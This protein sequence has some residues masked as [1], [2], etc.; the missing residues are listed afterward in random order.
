MP[1][2]SSPWI[3]QGWKSTQKVYETELP[4]K[5]VSETE[6]AVILQRLCCRHL[7][8]DEIVNASVRRASPRYDPRLEVERENTKARFS[9]SVSCHP[10]WYA[11]STRS[12][13]AKTDRVEDE[14]S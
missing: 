7:S 10:Y 12:V 5:S 1:Q 11:A 14:P 4:L 9:M 13:D 8:E 2:Q 3:V 6:M